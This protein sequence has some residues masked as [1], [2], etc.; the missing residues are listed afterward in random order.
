MK[1]FILFILFILLLG[2]FRMNTFGD[3]SLIQL[4]ARG[5][6]DKDLEI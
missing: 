3:G 1:W 4:A 6:E 2:I 5:I